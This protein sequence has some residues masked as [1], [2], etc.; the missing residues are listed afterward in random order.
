MKSTPESEFNE[1]WDIDHGIIA[2]EYESDYDEVLADSF[3]D[4]DLY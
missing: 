1:W 4:V 2:P 3:N